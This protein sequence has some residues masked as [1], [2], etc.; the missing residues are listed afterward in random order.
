[1]PGSVSFADW[2]VSWSIPT[3]WGG[4]LVV[5]H[6]RFRGTMVL[7]RGTVPFVLVPYHGNYPIFKDGI[8]HQG[9]PYTPVLPTSANA[10]QGPGTPPA[11]NDN[12][13]DPTT[14][15][16]GAVVVEQEAATLVEPARLVIWSKFQCV[17]YQYVHRWEFQ[18]DGSIEAGVG[19]G[20]VLWTKNPPQANH[21]HN[22]YFRLDLDIGGAG[23]N[24][25]QEFSHPNNIL[26]SDGWTTLTMEGRRTAIPTHATKWRV[27]NKVPKPNGKLRSYE[28]LAH[29]DMAPDHVSSSGD[30]WVLAY[31]P[32]QDGYAVGNDDRVL[33]TT[34]LHPPGTVV[35]GADVVV[36]CC[37]R[38]HH[39][40]RPVG[41]ETIT[42]PYEFLAL[43]LEPRDF[44][45]ATPTKLYPTTPPSP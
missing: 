5:A 40:A 15:P 16:K 20:G 28:I 25:V 1:M 27:V 22:F 37:V 43:H 41:E 35:D 9:A 18:A 33:H 31:D 32:S 44:L 19:L 29:S 45:D 14:N 4:G 3:G 30:L 23:N 42:L 21:V 8:N 24:A 6:A 17:N 11:N 13:W 38:H 36:W 34:Y 10:F 2:D 39:E 12:Q 7:W 26:G